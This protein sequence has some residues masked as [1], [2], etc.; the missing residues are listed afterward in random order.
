MYTHLRDYVL[1]CLACQQAKP[2]SHANQTPVLPLPIL[3]PGLIYNVDFHGP[4]VESEG[5][6]HILSFVE[7]TSVWVELV[8]TPS[9]D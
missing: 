7:H 6:K 1:S 8:A 2:D 4:F 9:V 5:N 3:Q